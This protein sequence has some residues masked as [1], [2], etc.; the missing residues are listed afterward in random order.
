MEGLYYDGDE[1]AV[2]ESVVLFVDL[3]GVSKMAEEDPAGNLALIHT[4]VQEA[5]REMVGDMEKE[6]F[7]H[8]TFSDS[9]VAAAPL[10]GDATFRELTVHQVIESASRLQYAFARRGIY[11]R[12]GVTIGEICVADQI[13]FGPGLVRAYHV[14]NDHAFFPRILL[15]PDC[16]VL[17]ELL[18]SRTPEMT[19]VRADYVRSDVDGSRFIDYL[20]PNLSI[21]VDDA[22]VIASLERQAAVVAERLTEFRDDARRWDIYRWV[23]EFLEFTASELGL[24]GDEFHRSTVQPVDLYLRHFSV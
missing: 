8:A 24:E 23:A 14:E 9:I 11:L 13:V 3:L 4:A 7:P 5:L 15:D 18:A 1:P 2:L 21:E 10:F 12:G 22:K 17:N 16:A 20:L 6:L 19:E